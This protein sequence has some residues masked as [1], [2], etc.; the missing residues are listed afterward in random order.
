MNVN[1]PIDYS[2]RY[3][4]GHFCCRVKQGKRLSEFLQKYTDSGTETTHLAGYNILVFKYVKISAGLPLLWQ[5]QFAKKAQNQT[6][7]NFAMF[8]SNVLNNKR[9]RQMKRVRLWKNIILWAISQREILPL[10][11][12]FLKKLINLHGGQL[13]LTANKYLKL[14]AY[15]PDSECCTLF[16][17]NLSNPRSSEDTLLYLYVV[18]KMLK[19]ADLHK[20]ILSPVI[21]HKHV[22]YQDGMTLC[23]SMKFPSVAPKET[24]SEYF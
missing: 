17:G 11:V 22:R 12:I 10:V 5:G 15:H 4:F 19:S 2:S 6:L 14:C 7:H 23:F 13:D 18:W 3:S 24:R 9:S 16:H 21:C 1:T 20:T 8:T